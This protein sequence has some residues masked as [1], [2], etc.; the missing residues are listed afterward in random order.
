MQMPTENV[1][2]LRS[3][4]TAS[5]HLPRAEQLAD[6]DADGIA[7][8]HKEATLNTFETVEQML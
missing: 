2:S 6:E 7:H 8:G 1:M 5:S 3:V 4:S